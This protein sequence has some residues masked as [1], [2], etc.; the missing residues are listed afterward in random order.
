[1]DMFLEFLTEY[2]MELL[3]AAII[4]LAGYLGILAKDLWTKHI[5]DKTKQQLA[6]IVVKGIEQC[7]KDLNGEEKLEEA[8]GALS[9]ML[10]ERG[11]KVTD[12]ELRM[13][14]ESAV[15]EFNDVFN[16]EKKS[17]D[18]TEVETDENPQG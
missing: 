13:L 15:A 16:K 14:I 10:N 11:I 8:L 5:N 1:M 4:A 7:Y 17:T 12:L 6:G 3:K 18:T 9:E 2:G